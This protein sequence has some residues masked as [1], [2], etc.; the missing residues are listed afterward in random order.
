MFEDEQ[1]AIHRRRSSIVAMD[2]SPEQPKGPL[3]DCFVHQL[4]AGHRAGAAVKALHQFIGHTPKEQPLLAVPPEDALQQHRQS[5]LLSKRELSEM[6]FNIRELSK[7]LAHI[8]LKLKVQNIFVLGKAHDPCVVQRTREL[9][10]WLLEHDPHHRVYVEN[11]LEHNTEFD[12]RGLLDEHPNFEN[13]VRYWDDVLCAKSPQIFDVVVAL[14]GDGTVLYASHLFQRIVPP[15]LAFALG[16]LGF[17]TKFD[18]NDHRHSLARVFAEGF[19]VN[20]RLRFEATIMRNRNR[21][22][23]KHRDIVEELID[24]DPN[25]ITHDPDGSFHILNEVVLDRGPNASRLSSLKT[26]LT[27]QP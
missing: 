22:D 9:T 8:K 13:R 20:L 5:R 4:L 25:T 14:G 7:K 19:N 26:R 11:T 3:T 10:E 24:G 23:L 27:M 18:F 1:A 16:S 17:L 21:E 6:S 15:V 2:R 12:A